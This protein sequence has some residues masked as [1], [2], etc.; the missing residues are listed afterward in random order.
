MYDIYKQIMENCY[1]NGIELY[2]EDHK[3]KYKSISGK[4]PE[5]IL[6]ELKRN[7]EGL[8]Q[9]ITAEAESE[10]AANHLFPLSPVQTSYLFGRGDSYSYGNVSCHIYQEFEYE[11][12][13]PIKVQEVWN[14]LIN[15]HGMLRAVIYE[16][17]YQEILDHTPE[18][19]ICQGETIRE[20]LENKVYALG[21]WPM[22][23]IG[24]SEADDK[25]I[26]H[27]SMDFL[28]ADWS[29]IWLILT[30]FEE[31]YFN[32][33]YAAQT[34][35]MT[36]K[37][38]RLYEERNRKS[39]DFRKA[40]EY[41]DNKL[42]QI[43]A[44]PELPVKSNLKEIKPGFCRFS[45][46]LDQESWM[47]I[48]EYTQQSGATPTSALLAVY[49]QVLKKWSNTKEFSVNLTL[50]HKKQIGDNMDVLVG[51]FT[52]TSIV[53]IAD[54]K[55]PLK[56]MVKAVSNTIFQNLDYSAY[57]GVEVLR[58]LAKRNGSKEFLLPYVFTSAIGLIQKPL[59]GRYKY[60][61]SQTPQVFIDFQAMET[62]NGLQVNWD[63]RESVFEK[64]IV[65]DMFDV[66][67]ETLENLSKS[68]EPWEEELRLPLPRWQE[69]ERIK[70]NSTE[71]KF[72]EKTL[73]DDF[74]KNAKS[75]PDKIA[76]ID[77]NGKITYGELYKKAMAI[78][79]KLMDSSVRQ[80]EHVIV[81][82]PHNSG[83]AA[84]VLGVLMTGAV[85]VPVDLNISK[86]WFQTIVTRCNSKVI[87][88][89][90]DI[91][92]EG[93][94]KIDIADIKAAD[95][96]LEISKINPDQTAYVIFTS[97][98]SGTPKGVVIS[99]RSAMNT[100]D[101]I[102]QKFDITSEDS[103]FA[104]SKLNFD[105]SVYDIFGTLSAG[106]TIIYPDE[107]DYLNPNH[108]DKLI[109]NCHITIWNSVP[110]LMELYISSLSEKK[111]IR[112]S[113]KNILLSGDWIPLKLPGKLKDIFINSNVIALGGATEA[114]IWSNYFRYE[115]LRDWW[116]SIPY[117][118]PLS[119]Q[120]F[121][122]L[123][124]KLEDC[125]VY[126]KGNLYIAGCGLAKMYLADEELTNRKFF[127]H[128]EKGIRLYSTG[129]LGRYLPGGDIEFLGREDKQVKIRGFRIELDEIKNAL[130]NQPGIKDA[131]VRV[132]KD[133]Q[134]LP[135]E[136]VVTINEDPAGTEAEQDLCVQGLGSP[137]A[138]SIISY[139]CRFIEN[140]FA[141]AGK[142]KVRILEI[143]AGTGDAAKEIM[144]VLE[145]KDY[146]Y[147]YTDSL[148]DV[149]EPNYF[150]IVVAASGFE[151]ADD[152]SA[153]F[154]AIKH[155]MAPK[156]Y[157]LFSKSVGDE[158]VSSFEPEKWLELLSL[159]EN[160]T[161]SYVFPE[162]KK[163]QYELGAV[164][165]IK[166]F[167]KGYQTI[168]RERIHDG[169]MDSMP[170]YMLPSKITYLEGFELNKNGKIDEAKSFELLVKSYKDINKET[171]ESY[172]ELNEL[173]TRIKETCSKLF[174]GGR[175]LRKSNFYDFDADS[176]V[177]AKLATEL[178]ENL[179]L[180]I[181]FEVLLR[182]VISSP[183]I[184]DVASF[185]EENRQDDSAQNNLRSREESMIYTKIYKMEGE[186]S[187][188]RL[189]VL[190]HGAFGNLDNFSKLAEELVL[191]NQGDILVIG[192]ADIDQFM[193]ID[194]ADMILKLSDIYS[195]AILSC[196]FDKVQIV[197]YSFSGLVAI[198]I[199]RRFWEQ[200]IDVENLSIIESG[201]MLDIDYDDLI[202]E[203]VFLQSMNIYLN[204][205]HIQKVEVF[206]DIFGNKVELT[207]PALLK[208]LDLE[209][210][211]QIVRD[212]DHMTQEERFD[213]Y[214]KI[215]EEKKEN[216]IT[217]KSLVEIFNI[218]KK[219]TKALTFIPD[220]YFGDID[221]YIASDN[222]GAYK[223]FNLLLENWNSILVGEINK[224]H[225][226]GNHY[227]AVQE[228]E[229]AK[230]LGNYLKLK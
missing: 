130:I 112:K 24:I 29:S 111:A 60:G 40:N 142:R 173:E 62:E 99:H 220:L 46:A 179:K 137:E 38:Y 160:R 27:F 90:D 193:E 162:E 28:I 47:K 65:S 91:P 18:Y 82:L 222:K 136:A 8:I 129:D 138:S 104:L 52:N 114:S 184:A 187:S 229:N 121:Y 165:F 95:P 225:I 3:L 100:I 195:A 226:P 45:A 228:Y 6:E 183:T 159:A 215:L 163:L 88:T 208:Y 115:G 41:W 79:G 155:V 51:D 185:I 131:I 93:L 70:A 141:Q 77:E 198:E 12:L 96:N 61:I 87:I 25:S 34:P 76:A 53:S 174:G 54:T 101:D 37:G 75:K 30:E 43:T 108:W 83:Q 26:L 110:A 207:V 146:E 206:D 213:L 125:P 203:F 209:T 13:D 134:E 72:H 216:S 151:P 122:I 68:Y 169:L 167:K 176:L 214:Y 58:D 200:G 157:F 16:E 150:D 126:C 19:T 116:V 158:N 149:A 17:G 186:N 97:G 98:T 73:I 190:V 35:S 139:D 192:I 81:R 202:L 10:E 164:L 140:Y 86:K 106:G 71:T 55:A 67:K 105:L 204:D 230:V 4:L 85:Y 194:S 188:G 57:S 84:S 80:G 144:K 21:K 154:A 196:E 135:I 102:N 221:Y 39:I 168:D 197:G 15:R 205:L 113:L 64:G 156:G 218:F 23:D 219:S 148:I 123:D 2:A 170:Q 59:R 78:A 212:L 14:Y 66:F 1:R 20:D 166:Q 199:A 147:H 210:D 224:Y 161:K 217:K 89:T 74:I 48:K 145:D 42:D 33:Y 128:P 107:A 44:A 152:R 7:K 143:G 182:G 211:Q 172:E 32:H 201:S 191:Q 227:T 223:Y 132:N 49:S 119:N 177:M 63:Y 171:G 31:V 180:S 178:K 22:F 94:T 69:E 56:S 109:E 124:E 50:F 36:F 120:Q 103:L 117:G 127:I 5:E 9:Y 153:A 133:R 11:S 189:R 175:L 92:E 118:K 181:S